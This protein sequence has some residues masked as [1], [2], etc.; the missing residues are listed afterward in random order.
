MFCS[1][2]ENV[3]RYN[4]HPPSRYQPNRG[5]VPHLGGR[6]LQSRPFVDDETAVVFPDSCESEAV[7]AMNGLSLNGVGGQKGTKRGQARRAR[8]CARA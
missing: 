2:M 3:R 5:T 1:R 4:G 6:G 7:Q 8:R